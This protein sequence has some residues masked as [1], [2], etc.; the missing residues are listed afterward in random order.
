MSQ[1][2]IWI[3][4]SSFETQPDE[5]SSSEVMATVC[6]TFPPGQFH[7]VDHWL[8]FVE[9][10]PALDYYTIQP[11]R[12]ACLYFSKIDPRYKQLRDDIERLVRELVSDWRV[13]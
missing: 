9:L 7:S 6:L 8:E 13:S 12:I 10:R 11:D 3:A 4:Q 2:R 1:R 5:E